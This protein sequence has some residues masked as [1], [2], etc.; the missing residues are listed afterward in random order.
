MGYVTTATFSLVL[1]FAAFHPSGFKANYMD[2]TLRSGGVVSGIGNTIGS[3]ASGVGPLLVANWKGFSGSWDG[4]LHSVALLNC[5]AAVIYCSC[6]S[7]TPIEAEE[8]ALASL[9]G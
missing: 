5:I 4:P 2:V 9:P 6:S 8:A 1:A 3:V 7:T